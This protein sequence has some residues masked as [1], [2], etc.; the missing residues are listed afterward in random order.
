MNHRD[1]TNIYKIYK[2]PILY[3]GGAMTQS[4]IQLLIGFV[5]AR[6]IPP[7]DLGLWTTLNIGVTYVSL[8]QAGLISGL[9]R[10]LPFSYGR[11]NTIEAKKLASTV[12]SI[13]LV[14]SIIILLAGSLCL[15]FYQF[16]NVKIKYGVIAITI[17]IVSLFFQNYFTSTYRSNNSFISLSKI[18]VINAI[19]NLLSVVLIIYLA[20]YGLIIKS[21]IVSVLFTIHLFIARPIKV[22]FKIDKSSLI[23]ILKTG[24]PIWGLS[25]VE[26]FASTFDKILLLKY[27]DLSSVG[28]YSFAYYGYSLFLVLSVTIAKYISPRMSYKYGQ[29]SD[30]KL[31]WVYFKKVTLF[32]SISQL[33]LGIIALIVLPNFSFKFFPQYKDSIQ[34]ML[35]LICAGML[36]GSIIGVNVLVSI[37]AFKYLSLYQVSYSIL[38]FISPLI[39]IY[40]FENPII[41]V[42]FGLLFANILN[43]MSGFYLT[44][45]ATNK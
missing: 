44:Y 36:K 37:K 14:T 15:L 26:S 4:I 6:F 17:H 40:L 21:V 13:T 23:K 29:N 41:G 24:L 12:Q 19:V 1:F 22:R 34:A 38:L 42:S 11:G 18:Q 9:N 35:I 33:I 10:E 25:Y 39:G 31:L 27:S 32:M 5:I 28:L 3:T 20:Y 43:Y 16:E 2:T 45:I 8:L 30:K 7:E